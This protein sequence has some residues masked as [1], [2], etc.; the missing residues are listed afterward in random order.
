MPALNVSQNKKT[1]A[2]V[3][4]QTLIIRV[5]NL[6]ETCPHCLN[7]INFIT[8]IQYGENSSNI[9]VVL[10]VNCTKFRP[11]IWNSELSRS[12]QN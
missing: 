1:T 9:Y 5:I 11:L 4:M 12:L 10:Q 8:I 7:H 3:H 6:T 2:S